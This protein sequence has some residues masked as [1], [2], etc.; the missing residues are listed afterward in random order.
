MATV[1]DS[2]EP[3]YEFAFADGS[4]R[5][6]AELPDD[7]SHDGNQIDRVDCVETLATLGRNDPECDVSLIGFS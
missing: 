2:N 3:V 6:T 5:T 1:A 4:T 7:Q